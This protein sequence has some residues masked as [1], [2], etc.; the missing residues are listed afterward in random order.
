MKEQEITKNISYRPNLQ[1]FLY[2]LIF[3][4]RPDCWTRLS[5][6]A[7]KSALPSVKSQ[8]AVCLWIIFFYHRFQL[9][10]KSQTEKEKYCQRLSFLEI[11]IYHL[12]KKKIHHLRLQ[13]NPP[14]LIF[15]KDQHLILNSNLIPHRMSSFD[16]H[17]MKLFWISFKWVRTNELTRSIVVIFIFSKTILRSSSE[18]RS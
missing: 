17:H 2:N 1:N 6:S 12:L 8:Q 10:N 11:V 13:M 15:V 3:I 7:D 5:R 9:W 18:R 16:D 4:Y 14:H